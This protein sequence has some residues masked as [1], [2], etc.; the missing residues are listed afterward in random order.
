MEVLAI[1]AGAEMAFVV[2]HHL[3]RLTVVLG[4]PFVARRARRQVATVE[5][6]E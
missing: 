4:A 3:V 1:V 5:R 2:T 6:S